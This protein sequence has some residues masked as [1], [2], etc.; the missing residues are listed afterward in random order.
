MGRCAGLNLAR[1]R[2]TDPENGYENRSSVFSY[3]R[4]PI[5]ETVDTPS[6]NDVLRQGIPSVRHSLR[7]KIV[8]A[9]HADNVVFQSLLLSVLWYPRQNGS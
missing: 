9:N 8:F 4:S 5:P 3:E 7:E 6:I 2:E 1:S